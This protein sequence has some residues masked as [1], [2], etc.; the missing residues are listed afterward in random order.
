MQKQDLRKQ[1]KG[2]LAQVTGNQVHID[3]ELYYD[4]WAEITTKNFLKNTAIVRM[5][6][7]QKLWRKQK[8]L[9][10]QLF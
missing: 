4:D 6:L 5:R 2:K 7:V 9:L 10:I 1:P 8:F 3:P